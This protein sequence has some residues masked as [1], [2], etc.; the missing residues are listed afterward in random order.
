M[1]KKTYRFGYNRDFPPFCWEEGKV[2]MGTV[3]ERAR[4]AATHAGLD[5]D[6]VPLPL[7]K[8][9]GALAEGKIDAVCGLGDVPDRGETLA[10]SD[11]LAETGG[12]WFVPVGSDWPDGMAYGG[13]ALHHVRRVLTV[14]T[15]R[16]GPLLRFLRRSHPGMEV[17]GLDGYDACFQAVLDGR[18]DAAAL[19]LDVGR[20]R[21]ER[22]YPGKFVLPKRPFL[23]VRMS[24]ACRKSDSAQLLDKF[25]QGLANV[26]KDAGV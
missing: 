19:N 17:I 3:I 26:P 25:N 15:P 5:I 14:A 8:L 6:L 24:L 10:F 9:R 4:A 18:A 22:D 1:A 21:A 16:G 7:A 11:P 2:A 13:A 23:P 12:A 20:E